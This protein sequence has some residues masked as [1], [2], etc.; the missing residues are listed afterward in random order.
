[1][2]LSNDVR[3]FHISTSVDVKHLRLSQKNG[4]RREWIPSK[5]GFPMDFKEG[6]KAGEKVGR[7]RGQTYSVL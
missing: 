4:M 3:L 1:M 7:S 5:K 6:S 2:P